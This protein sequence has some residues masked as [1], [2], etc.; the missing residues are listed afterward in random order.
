M[1]I[2]YLYWRNLYDCIYKFYIRNLKKKHI[3]RRKYFFA[4]N[5]NNNNNHIKAEISSMACYS[6]HAMFLPMTPLC[7]LKTFNNLHSC[8]ESSSEDVTI[9]TV[10]S[11]PRKAY[12]R[13]FG[14]GFNSHVGTFSLDGN[15][16]ISQGG[17]SLYFNFQLLTTNSCADS[18]RQWMYTI[19]EFSSKLKSHEL[20]KQ[21]SNAW[22]WTVI[23]IK[24][25]SCRD[26]ARL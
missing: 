9:G 20:T 26:G 8:K 15:N 17:N 13:S 22:S 24:L 6:K 23:S 3:Y 11:V 2:K 10:S 12:L 5:N 18:K 25:T 7:L 14:Q 1:C 19:L 21:V 4:L 16:F